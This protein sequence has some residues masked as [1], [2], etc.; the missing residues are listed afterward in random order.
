MEAMCPCTRAFF[1]HDAVDLVRIADNRAV[2]AASSA[3]ARAR[4]LKEINTTQPPSDHFPTI[5]INEDDAR[6]NRG[7]TGPEGAPLAGLPGEMLEN[8]LADGQA[9]DHDRHEYTHAI[10]RALPGWSDRAQQH[11]Q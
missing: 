5:C 7:K 2:K 8:M 4:M 11:D 9:H 1:A 6:K 3:P 10:I